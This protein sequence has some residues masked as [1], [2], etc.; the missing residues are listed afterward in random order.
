MENIQKKH[1][2]IVHLPSIIFH[3]WANANRDWS[4]SNV[5]NGQFHS[6]LS[7][8]IGT[9][10]FLLLPN[11]LADFIAS[12]MGRREKSLDILLNSNGQLKLI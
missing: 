4:L 8:L 9:G 11:N 5:Q 1:R 7:I 3:F 12:E 2:A 10:G 6:I